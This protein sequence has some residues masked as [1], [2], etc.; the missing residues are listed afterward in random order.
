MTE[1]LPVPHL[2]ESEPNPHVVRV[3][4]SV[5]S[6]NLLLGKSPLLWPTIPFGQTELNVRV[7]LCSGEVPF[8]YGYGGTAK[9]S[10]NLEFS[11]YGVP[12]QLN[13][14]VGVYMV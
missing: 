3:G 2:E 12:F 14:V 4:W 11:D 1:H 9:I 5:D 10:Q 6:T 13:D 7:L 8:S